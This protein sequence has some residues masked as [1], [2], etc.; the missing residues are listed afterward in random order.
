[1]PSCPPASAAPSSSPTAGSRDPGGGGAAKSSRPA[2]G[3]EAGGSECSL[4]T[5]RP[6]QTRDALPPTGSPRGARHALAT[7]ARQPPTPALPVPP[8]T[9]AAAALSLPVDLVSEGAALRGRHDSPRPAA[10]SRVWAAGLGG[11]GARGGGACADRAG[12]LPRPSSAAEPRRGWG[13][14]FSGAGEGLLQEGRSLLWNGR[15]LL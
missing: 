5:P 12:P 2:R 1:M 9:A 13:G 15:G 11:T 3:R 14:A 7:A 8:G 4:S 10:A 6:A